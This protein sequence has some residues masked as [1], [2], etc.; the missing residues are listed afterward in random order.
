MTANLLI[1]W[2]QLTENMHAF[3]SLLQQSVVVTEVLI[4]IGCA[5][6]VDVISDLGQLAH[7][8]V[9]EFWVCLGVGLLL[10]LAT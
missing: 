10:E 6:C 1:A 5:L 7:I 3:L 4:G 8:F 9:T 2:G